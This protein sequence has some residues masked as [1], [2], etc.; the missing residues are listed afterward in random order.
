MVEPFVEDGGAIGAEDIFLVVEL[1][2]EEV[3][4]EGGDVGEHFWG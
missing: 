2:E 4:A 1:Y 3:V